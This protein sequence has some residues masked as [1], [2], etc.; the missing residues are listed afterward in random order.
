MLIA[1]IVMN[2]KHVGVHAGG[3]CGR[4]NAEER[5]IFMS[6]SPRGVCCVVRSVGEVSVRIANHKD[7][8]WSRTHHSVVVS[9][10]TH[11][12]THMRMNSTMFMTLP[13][14]IFQLFMYRVY[15]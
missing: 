13:I 8:F 7:E 12:I 14:G 2:V 3:A 11:D 1:I 9:I 5:Q 4:M 6:W 15:N 10:T